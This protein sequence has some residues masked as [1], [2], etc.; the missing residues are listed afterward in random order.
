MKPKVYVETTIVSYLTAR[1]SRDVVVAGH[2]QTTHEWWNARRSA[3]DL[4]ASQLVVQEAGAGNPEVAE[5]RLAVLAGTEVL[6]LTDE[7][8]HLARALIDAGAIPR[9]AVEDALHVAIAVTNGIDYLL[10]WNYHH[11]ANAARRGA[12]EAVCRLLGYEP[13]VICTPEAL[14]ED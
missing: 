1:P 3:F 5:R 8:S 12:I 6:A 7:A 2:Q 9:E 4:V 10:T 13:V 11:L 14:L